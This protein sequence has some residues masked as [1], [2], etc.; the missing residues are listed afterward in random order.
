MSTPE[1]K[2]SQKTSSSS[3][4]EDSRPTAFK[5]ASAFM[6]ARRERRR[7]LPFDEMMAEIRRENAEFEVKGLI[8]PAS[9]RRTFD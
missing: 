3:S 5:E 1:A 6:R 7:K 9:E 2:P 4:Q 8:R